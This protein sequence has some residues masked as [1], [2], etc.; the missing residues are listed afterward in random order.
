M[1]VVS[2]DQWLMVVHV[3]RA[4]A[5][6]PLRMLQ[7]RHVVFIPETLCWTT[8]SIMFVLRHGFVVTCVVSCVVTCV[9]A[10]ALECIAGDWVTKPLHVREYALPSLKPAD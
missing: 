5:A 1:Y 7:V 9:V 6:A 10:A 4:P 8:T 2:V 3:A